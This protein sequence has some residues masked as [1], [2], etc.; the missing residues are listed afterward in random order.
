VRRARLL[1][2]WTDAGLSLQT[3]LALVDRGAL[4]LMFLDA[5]VM[6]CGVR[7]LIRGL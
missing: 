6:A 7:K 4:S 5:P 1:H 3:I 2:S